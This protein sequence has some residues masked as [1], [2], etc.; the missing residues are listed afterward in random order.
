MAKRKLTN[1]TSVYVRGDSKAESVAIAAR[2]DT[3]VAFENI[4]AM[5][6]ERGIA[7]N[8]LFNNMLANME[9]CMRDNWHPNTRLVGLNLGFIKV[10]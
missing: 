6:V 2:A 4:R 10:D 5:C 8:A 3:Q 1:S 7:F 9:V